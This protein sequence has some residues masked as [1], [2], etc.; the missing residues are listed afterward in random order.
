MEL[1]NFFGNKNMVF[2]IGKIVNRADPL[3]VGRCQVRIF[4]YHTDN[5]VLLPDDDLPWAL[6]LYP[7]NASNTFSKPRLDDW[8]MGFFMDGESAQ[9]PVMMGIISGLKEVMK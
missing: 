9:M 7:I 2:W 6:A 4:G 3:G 8:V 1:N 5:K